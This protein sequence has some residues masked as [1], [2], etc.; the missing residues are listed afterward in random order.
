MR[1]SRFGVFTVLFCICAVMMFALSEHNVEIHDRLLCHAMGIDFENG[2]YRVTIQA[3]KPSGAGSD[4]PID[5]TKSNIEIISAS[6]RTVSEALEQCESF[7]G[8]TVFLGHLQLICL[9][10]STDLSDP[11]SLFEFCLKDRTVFLGVNVCLSDTTAA[12]LMQIEMTTDTLSTENYTSVIEKNSEKARTVKCTLLDFFKNGSQRQ[13]LAIPMLRAR[14]RNT[15]KPQT[16]E[17][18]GEPLLEVTGTALIK[19]GQVLEESVGTQG[20]SGLF[21]LFDECRRAD[22]VLDTNGK[23]ISVQTRKKS[24]KQRISV[25]NGIVIYRPKLTVVV[26]RLKDIVDSARPQ[27]V[28]GQISQMLSSQIA[29]EAGKCL[30][31]R[32]TDIFGLWK[33]LRQRYPEMYLESGG[34]MDRIYEQVLVQPEVECLVE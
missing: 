11:E 23:K 19:D 30:N 28:A 4:T 22:I 13:D 8:K 16:E 24:L 29:D 12:E 25:Q 17:Q 32:K 15:D 31:D 2:E 9:G 27:E 14:Q 7:R 33:H 20:S 21:L 10:R 3:F 18:G 34:N 1:Y 5:I 6:G 26:E